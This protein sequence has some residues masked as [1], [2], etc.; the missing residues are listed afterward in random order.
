M[1]Y[2]SGGHASAQLDSGMLDIFLLGSA[3]LA[4]ALARGVEVQLIYVNK[5]IGTDEAL[6][7]RRVAGMPPRRIQSPKD[8]AGL[9]VGVP[10]GSSCHYHLI[11]LKELFE[12]CG[13]RLVWSPTPHPHPAATDWP[14]P[15]L[16]GQI[17]LE[18]RF[19][20][21]SEMLNAWESGRIDAAWSW[22]PTKTQLLRR[23]GFTL[24]N[25]GLLA[26]WGRPT[27]NLIV[28]RSAFLNRNRRFVA[29]VVR[30][31]AM[32]DGAW[33]REA[34]LAAAAD[35]LADVADPLV[36]AA[37]ALQAATGVGALAVGAL[38]VEAALG[39]EAA[40]GVEALAGEDLLYGGGKDSAAEQAAAASVRECRSAVEKGIEQAG[41]AVLAPD[42][43]LAS[44]ADAAGYNHSLP[45][46]R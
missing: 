16:F 29:R 28:A 19:M 21:P 13:A 39:A 4:A 11:Y 3:A 31:M 7:S 8:L 25:S 12:V 26:E 32:L 33:L 40:L 36:G 10:F 42:S 17:E 6:V 45:S 1:P 35:G 23:G 9:T 5:V 2:S 37:A 38:A 27:L 41:F 30:L 34:T 20:P 14:P 43:L 24:V 22:N 18:I 15:G 44:I 46:A